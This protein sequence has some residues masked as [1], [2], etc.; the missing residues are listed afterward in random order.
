MR[1]SR[2]WPACLTLVA[3][4]LALLSN[5]F[6]ETPPIGKAL[7]YVIQG[8]TGGFG[9]MLISVNGR[10]VESVRTNS[11]VALAVEP[12]THEIST[13]TAG[14]AA[15]S[16]TVSAG[17]TS[18][19]RLFVDANGTAIFRSLPATEGQALLSTHQAIRADAIV[20]HPPQPSFR[21]ESTADGGAQTAGPT[22]V[23]SRWYAGFGLGQS[24]T[25][26][27]SVLP[28]V[29][30]YTLFVYGLGCDDPGINCSSTVEDKDTAFKVFAG[31]RINKF[32]S[33]EGLYLDFGKP[34]SKASLTDGFDTISLSA[35][36]E[37]SGLGVA[38]VGF[39]PI[40]DAVSLLAKLG[41]FRWK[42]ETKATLSDTA[43]ATSATS[44]DSASGSDAMYGI[45]LEFPAGEQ[46]IV[47]MEW[48]Q[49]KDIGDENETGQSDFDLMSI[50]ALFKF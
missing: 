18:Y 19:V 1:S 28:A 25:D 29:E 38:A 27:A 46:W 16:L 24:K 6:A 12:G 23:A 39:V 40:S 42:L 44:S 4:G 8:E 34:T 17:E 20:T 50:N 35:S 3:G 45:G 26:I 47:R 14:R 22:M 15:I 33:V 37:A 43:F 7:V 32:L 10:Q 11:Y 2:I 48:E 30:D 49:F 13:A 36:F 41:L 9:N 31:Y 5:A 21:S